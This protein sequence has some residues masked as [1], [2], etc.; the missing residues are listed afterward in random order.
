MATPSFATDIVITDAYVYPSSFPVG[1]RIFVKENV[2]TTLPSGL[3]FNQNCTFILG[4][5]SDVTIETASS[6]T[7]RDNCGFIMQP[8]S[9]FTTGDGST[10]SFGAGCKVDLSQGLVYLG[11]Y[12]IPENRAILKLGKDTLLKAGYQIPITGTGIIQA[13]EFNPKATVQEYAIFE[14]PAIQIFDEEIQIT[15]NWHMDRAYPQWFAPENCTNWATPIHK[16]IAMKRTGEVFLQRGLYK[17]KR[18]IHIPYGIQLVGETGRRGF[19]YTNWQY[20]DTHGTIIAASLM[21]DLPDQYSWRYFDFGSMILINF[22]Q[23][24]IPSFSNNKQP[25]NM[26]NEGN[27]W[28]R[29]F[30]VATCTA[31]RHIALANGSKLVTDEGLDKNNEVVPELTAVFVAGG[32]VFEDLTFGAFKQAIVKTADYAD[33]MQIFDCAFSK[34]YEFN[35]YP[36]LSNGYKESEEENDSQNALYMVQ[37]NGSGDNLIFRGNAFHSGNE[38]NYALSIVSCKGGTIS[39]NIINER[40]RISNCRAI[41]FANNHM[42]SDDNDLY[43]PQLRIINSQ[44]TVSSNFFYKSDKNNIVVRGSTSGEVCS[45]IL[46]NNTFSCRFFE[47]PKK[48]VTG[49]GENDQHLETDEEYTLRYNGIVENWKRRSNSA[50]ICINPGA[51][52]QLIKQFRQINGVNYMTWPTQVGVSFRMIGATGGDL[53]PESVVDIPWFTILKRLT[54]LS[55]Y[56]SYQGCI[57]TGFRVENL[58]N[59]QAITNIQMKSS[60]SSGNVRWYAESGYYDYYAQIVFDLERKIIGTIDGNKVK[61]LMA[62]PEERKSYCECVIDGK[63][64]NSRGTILKLYNETL[65]IGWDATLHV[66]RSYRKSAEGSIE[67]WDKVAIPICGAEILYDNGITL[68]GYLWEKHT[69]NNIPTITDITDGITAVTFRN[70]NVECLSTANPSTL[71]KGTWQNGDIIYN[72]GTD[73]SWNIYIKK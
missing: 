73:E 52:V 42:E 28:D 15:G 20:K 35:N 46:E 71:L 13:P 57:K 56:L 40:V 7:F 58:L 68:S 21:S 36:A 43:G 34:S 14:A 59:T 63:I 60:D 62:S 3:V 70:S 33:N 64:S 49:V 51:D 61:H 5:N 18:S 45:A 11:S 26:K 30:P 69:D 8:G 50:E 17:I 10:L 27:L 22:N 39:D 32:C 25:S 29:A 1:S 72:V 66:Y 19:D 54:T 48:Y 2:K 67:R 38:Y 12:Y 55:P 53:D 65:S 4:S 31:L 47:I 16:A 23:D 44:I 6:V 41:T 9:Q 37:L 24:K